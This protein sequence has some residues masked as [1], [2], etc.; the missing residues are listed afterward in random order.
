MKSRSPNHLTELVVT[1]TGT[2]SNDRVMVHDSFGNE[3]EVNGTVRPKGS[4]EPQVDERWIIIKRMGLW[5]FSAMVGVPEPKQITGEREGLH[6]VIE[7]ILDALAAAGLVSDLTIPA[8]SSVTSGDLSLDATNDAPVVDPSDPEELM[9]GDESYLPSSAD[10]SP[11]PDWGTSDSTEEDDPA[12]G[13]A[14]F[15][16][17]SIIT[18][19]QAFSLGKRRAGIDM[20]H[21][22]R[23]RADVITFQEVGGT[24]RGSVFDTRDTDQWG[25][26][27]PV[28]VPE[29]T[30]MWRTETC[31]LID[32]GVVVLS[33]SDGPGTYRPVRGISWVRLRH[34]PSG[35]AFTVA[36]THLDAFAAF[37]GVLKGTDRPTVRFREQMAGI[38]PV[39]RDLAPHGPLFLTGDFNVNFRADLRL[40]NP[41]L[42]YA[43]FRSLGLH[44]NW[45]RL[46]LPDHGGTVGSHGS[47]FDGIFLRQKV[48]GQVT[49]RWQKILSGYYSDHRPVMVT[50]R[51][52]NRGQRTR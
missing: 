11:D 12:L 52:R 30:I 16:P 24:E 31:T 4:G 41:G 23:T 42:P 27:R 38:R 36:D 45:D 51:V 3:F 19:N 14:H 48:P 50:S 9:P 47:I 2:R 28:E 1:V 22:M 26:Y 32:S 17:L 13:D 21:L 33:E 43:T 25:M 5:F 46:G 39:L 40:R 37:G 29:I 35:V 10:L 8:A 6:P 15:S 7:Q 34:E 18:Y 44:S 20:R 49:M